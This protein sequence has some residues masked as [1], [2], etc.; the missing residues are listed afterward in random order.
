[1]RF[2]N[3]FAQYKGTKAY[4]TIK[5]IY[6]FNLESFDNFKYGED[7]AFYQG[8]P[9]TLKVSELYNFYKY[10]SI[11][12]LYHLY[13]FSSYEVFLS[14]AKK[15]K[16]S[17]FKC[18]KYLKEPYDLP[19]ECEQNIDISI[20]SWLKLKGYDIAD[21]ICGEQH[22]KDAVLMLLAGVFLHYIAGY[23]FDSWEYEK[24]KKMQE[25]KTELEKGA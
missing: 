25:I 23:L 22:I 20:D 3:K 9:Q 19:P 21:Y 17:I 2:N 5:E 7:N 8:K 13:G 11:D 24:D 14:F 6:S 16:Q 10:G 12:D 15:Y 4:K 18:Y 1:M